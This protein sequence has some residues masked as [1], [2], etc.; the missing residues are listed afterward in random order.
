MRTRQPGRGRSLSVSIPEELVREI[1]KIL[2]VRKSGYESRP[3]FIKGG[4]RRRL[5]E[6]KRTG[7]RS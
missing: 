2:S 6:F 4:I 5:E 7:V 3:E 1:V